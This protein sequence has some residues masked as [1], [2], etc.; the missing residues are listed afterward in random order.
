MENLQFVLTMKTSLL[1]QPKSGAKSR[2]TFEL[3]KQNNIY[4]K[5]KLN[6]LHTHPSHKGMG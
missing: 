2:R 1:K 4:D 5:L 3:I 6:L